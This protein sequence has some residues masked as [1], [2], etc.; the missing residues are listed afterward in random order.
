M[1]LIKQGRVLQDRW[2]T[3]ETATE[4]LKPGA[5]F[6]SLELWQAERELLRGK[7]AIGITLPNDTDPEVLAP[8][9]DRI[10][11]VALRFPAFTDG[12]GFSQARTLREHLGFRG[13]I[14]AEGPLIPDQHQFLLRCGVDAVVVDDAADTGPWLAAARRY[15][16]V[17][18]PAADDRIP[19][20]RGRH[21]A[22]QAIAS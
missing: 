19:A 10:A 13:E 7:T 17:Y 21:T 3:A 8:D 5:Y 4:A 15:R 12:R 2:Q 11:A 16:S 14:R 22:P 1:A 20:Y 9:L 6:V 18:Q